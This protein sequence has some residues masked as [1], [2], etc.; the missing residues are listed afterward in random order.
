[1]GNG[2]KLNSKRA[3]SRKA[4]LEEL[5]AMKSAQGKED[6]SL[7]RNA[8]QGAEKESEDCIL[9]PMRKT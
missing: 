4:A 3:Y 6:R 9:I 1:M 8:S 7:R 5:A 2:L